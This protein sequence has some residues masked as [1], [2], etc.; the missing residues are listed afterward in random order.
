M[1]PFVLRLPV[2]GALTANGSH[3]RAM[4]RSLSAT[5]APSGALT[6]RTSRLLSAAQGFVGTLASSKAGSL[7]AT[8]I[9]GLASAAGSR[10]RSLLDAVAAIATDR[11]PT[12]AA[13]TDPP[14][15]ASGDDSTPTLG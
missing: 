2:S 9:L 13:P 7:V 3:S 12:G 11:S 1:R 5:L 15:I 8:P 14:T 4:A 10:M 6:K